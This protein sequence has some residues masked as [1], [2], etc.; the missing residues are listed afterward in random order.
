M[1]KKKFHR[2][3][4]EDLSTE[5]DAPAVEESLRCRHILLKHEESRNPVSR[6]TGEAT[7]MT[8]I[9]EA[10]RDLELLVAQIEALGSTEEVF[11]KFAKDNSDCSSFKEG[12]DLG[13]FMAGEMQPEFEEGVRA[14][15]V[16]QV[17][18]IIDSESGE[19]P[20]AIQ[21]PCRAPSERAPS[22]LATHAGLHIVFRTK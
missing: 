21:R 7:D 17:S 16:G 20:R 11:A 15:A 22:A 9:E 1:Q 4:A 3:S 19:C 5:P 13:E 2:M 6:R 18:K 8:S 12:G 14:T 10:R